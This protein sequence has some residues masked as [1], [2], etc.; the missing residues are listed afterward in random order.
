MREVETR[1]HSQSSLFRDTAYPNFIVG[2][3]VSVYT[4]PADRVLE[5]HNLG[6]LDRH[7]VSLWALLLPPPP[8]LC[9]SP[10]CWRACGS[11]VIGKETHWLSGVRP[12]STADHCLD[13][14]CQRPPVAAKPPAYPVASGAQLLLFSCRS[15]LLSEWRLNLYLPCFLSCLPTSAMHPSK[16]LVII[17]IPTSFIFCLVSPS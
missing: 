12:W 15:L 5:E 2:C 17:Y 13:A 14:L 6:P 4:F 16:P 10:I 7:L 8:Y 9:F 1:N 11:H 3:T